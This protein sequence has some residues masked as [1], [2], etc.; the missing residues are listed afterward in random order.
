[1]LNNGQFKPGNPPWN[2]GKKMSSETREKISK[3]KKEN[4]IRYWLGKNHSMEHTEKI[5]QKQIG[6]KASEETKAKMRLAASKKSKMSKEERS[7]CKN[8][9]NRMKR[10]NGGQHTYA[11]W[12]NLKAQYNWTCPCC[13]KVEPE[14]KL[15]EDHIIPVSKGGSDNIDNIQ[16]LCLPCNVRKY[17]RV[18][19]Y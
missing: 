3:A 8:K 10:S 17:T 2:K 19:R 6:R 11:E 18:V 5:R 15:T 12:Y 4:P 7:W 1:M 16:P 13:K 9:R 14:I